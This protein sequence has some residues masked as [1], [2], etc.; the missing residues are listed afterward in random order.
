MYGEMFTSFVWLGNLS[1]EERV[2]NVL[3]GDFS[4]N[5]KSGLK[6]GE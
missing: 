6:N 4:F 3:V 5:L 1:C 2:K